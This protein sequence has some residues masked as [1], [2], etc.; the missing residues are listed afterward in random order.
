[1]LY[2]SRYSRRHSLIFI[3]RNSVDSRRAKPAAGLSFVRGHSPY[4]I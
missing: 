4:C 3:R 1:M 2:K